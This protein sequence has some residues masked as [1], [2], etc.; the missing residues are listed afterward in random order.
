MSGRMHNNESI[1]KVTKVARSGFFVTGLT[2]EIQFEKGMPPS[3]ARAKT[4]LDVIVSLQSPNKKFSSTSK[5]ASKTGHVGASISSPV[6]D[7]EV[8][9]SAKIFITGCSVGPASTVSMSSLHTKNID[10]KMKNPP[11]NVNPT[12]LIMAQGAHAEPFTV[13]SAIVALA[14]YPTIVKGPIRVPIMH[15]K[16]VDHD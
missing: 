13:S 4:I 11:I 3:L 10:N 2:C 15:T 6:G 12:F 1:S 5:I 8:K 7:T 14:S 9:A 16:A